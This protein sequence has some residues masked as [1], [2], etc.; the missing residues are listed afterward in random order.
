MLIIQTEQLV[1]CTA[2]ALDA[3]DLVDT[4]IE[5]KH[6]VSIYIIWSNFVRWASLMQF[7][8]TRKYKIHFEMDP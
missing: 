6:L 3:A 4:P 1:L 5:K 8:K 2:T 7:A